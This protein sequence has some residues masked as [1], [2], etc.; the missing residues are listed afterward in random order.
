[1]EIN[2]NILKKTPNKM[3]NLKVFIKFFDFIFISVWGLTVVDLLKIAVNNP[4]SSIDNWVKT[5]MAIGGLIYLVFSIPH[6]IKMQT[7]ERKMK[8]EEIEKLE[9]ENKKFR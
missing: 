6:K 4:Y 2:N 3:T 1:M 9:H 7:L 8:E 5:L